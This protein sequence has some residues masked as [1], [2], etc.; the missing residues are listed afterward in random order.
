VADW[1]YDKVLV[2]PGKS[3][4]AVHLGYWDSN[5]NE[6]GHLRGNAKAAFHDRFANVPYSGGASGDLRSHP[7]SFG[8]F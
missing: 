7:L 4:G 5:L 3:N 8:A 1:A 2:T 6:D